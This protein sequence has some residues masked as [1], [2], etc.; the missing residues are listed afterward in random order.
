MIG[1]VDYTAVGRP[2]LMSARVYATVEEMTLSE[3]VIVFKK[4]RRKRYQKSQGHKQ[5]L[6][7]IRIDKI[8]HGLTEEEFST[9]ALPLVRDDN[10]QKIQVR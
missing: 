3:K 1:T 5:M 4:S 6:N 2:N 7:I 8:E 9:Y 10:T